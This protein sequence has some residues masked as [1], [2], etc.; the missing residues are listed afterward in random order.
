MNWPS[1]MEQGY[2]W[3]SFGQEGPLERAKELKQ[4]WGQKIA[5]QKLKLEPNF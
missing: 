4:I 3:L 5:L 2:I 1:L